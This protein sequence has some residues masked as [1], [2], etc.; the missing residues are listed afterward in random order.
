MS[1]ARIH[2]VKGMNDLLPEASGLWQHLE[3]TARRVFALS[4][5]EEV[6]TPLLEN[7]ALFV[8]GIGEETDVVGK[9]MYTFEDRGGES[10]TLRPEGT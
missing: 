5:F 7:T 4:G 10:L 8:R 9:E 3:E 1:D 6:R 2:A